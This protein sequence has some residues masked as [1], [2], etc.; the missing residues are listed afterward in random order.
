MPEK[1]ESY[2]GT[3]GQR[4]IISWMMAVWQ[5]EQLRLMER[6]MFLMKTEKKKALSERKTDGS[7]MTETGTTQKTE[8]PMMDGWMEHTIYLMGKWQLI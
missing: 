1:T 8:K 2:I 3:S 7:C 4:T 6:H 5:S